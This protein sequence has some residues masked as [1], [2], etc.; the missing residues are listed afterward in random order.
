MA[1]TLDPA[2]HELRRDAFVDVAL[3]LMTVKGYDRMSIQDVLNDAGASRGAFYHYFDSKATLREAVLE[4]MVDAATAT[5]GPIVDDPDLPAMAKIEG[6]FNGIARWKNERTELLVGVLEAW[7]T[8]EN[9]IVRERYRH[10]V[11]GRL[12]PILARIVEQGQAD[13]VFTTT[14]PQ[15]VARVLASLILATNDTALELYY[16]RQAGTVAFEEVE[17]QFAA[18]TDAYERILGLPPSTWPTLDPAI[19]RQ[20]F[21]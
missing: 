12:T 16:A 15:S 2:A 9:A 13:G 7:M 11:T 18:F 3:R 10:A 14:D 6:L 1:R 20:W 8:D 19:L 17:R 4:R 21:G 5:I